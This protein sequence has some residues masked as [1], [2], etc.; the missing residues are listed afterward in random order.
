MGFLT[1]TTSFFFLFLLILFPLTSSGPL[2]T[3]SIYPNFTASHYQ[4]ID[5]GGAFLQSTNG[6]FKV[7]FTKPTSNNSQYYLSI[8]H[9]LSNSIIWTAN[10]NKPVSDSSKLSL[11]ADGLAISD[12]D[13]RFVWSTPM[14]DSPVSSMQLQESGNLV[15]LDA[16]NV[17]LWQSFDSPTDAIVTG[18]TLRVGKSLAASVS[19]NDL[20]VGE[21]S[22]VVTD[23]DGVLQWNQMTYWKL[24]MYSYAFKD[25]DAP[26]SF[27]SVN[28]T[29]LYLLASDGSRFVL[30]VSLDAAGFRIAKLEPSGRLIVSKLVGDNLVQELAIPVENCRIPFFCKEI[31]LCSGGS[32]SC[33][34]GF[35]AELNGDCVPINSSL[36]L[37]NGCSAT[38]ASG[39]NSSITYLKLGNGVDY[40]ANDFIQPV[41]RGV[42]LSDCQD[43]CS[44]NCSCL[45]IFHD[46]SSESCYFIENHLGTLMSSSDNERVRLGYIKAM[47]LSSDGSKKAEDENGSKFPVAGLVLI[48]SSLLAIA[49]VV[50]FLWWRINS[51]RARAK[52]I[53][54]G[55]RNSSSEE[56]EL[57]SIA[58]LP[59]RFSYEELAAATDN[60]NTPIGSGGFGTVYKGILQDKSVVAVKKINSFGIQGKKEFCTEITIIGN[61][62][63]VN[64]VRLKGFCAQGRQRFLVYEYMNKGSLDRTLFGNGSVLEWRERF[65]IALGT[66][67]GL[68]YLHTG[69]DHKIIHCDVKPENILLHDKLQ[70][71][72][73]DFGLSKLLTPEQSSLFTTMRGTRGY[74]A[75][76]WLTSSAISDKTDVYSYGMVLLEIISG[77]K[78]SSLKIQSRSTEKDSSGDGNGPSS[79]SSPRE[80]QRVYFPLLA[81]E[82]HEQRRYLELADSRIE[83]QVSDEDVE[84][85]VRIALCCVQEEPMLRPSM[86]NV[87]SMLEGG[88]PLGEPR[89]ES[90]RFLRFYGQRFNEASTIEE[91]NELNLQFIL[92][93]ETNGT[94]T[95]GSYNSLS[96]ISSQQVSGPR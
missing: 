86:A 7:S 74:L 36:S 11:S 75:P 59:R 94:N 6:T 20:S 87:V 63:H 25:S 24:S 53:K 16:R 65:E 55:S 33:P 90:L 4:F 67:R 68:A 48:P 51:K 47:V 57:T 61:I 80:S 31:G 82:L 29:G 14:L 81:L 46:D 3:G 79:S 35:H 30:K 54:L 71:K 41:K 69:C 22:F 96:Y 84:K 62:H 88:M 89:I 26:V 66:A 8:L 50:G 21:Y 17:S 76:E 73:S 83:G 38:N 10:R 52:V 70:V 60:F 43:L 39:L 19:E 91:S 77:R 85:L 12:D 34:S 95:T 92:Q 5:Q 27:L 2:R 64:L 23:G 13:D 72:I 78:N 1:I 44:W 56:L 18:Q 37:P 49:I 42:G 28:R 93:S 58:G 15:L 32:C 9:S 45:G 40:F